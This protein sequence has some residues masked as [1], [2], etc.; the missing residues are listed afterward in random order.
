MATVPSATDL[1][2]TI[3]E[4]SRLRILNALVAA[5]LFVSDLQA[6]LGLPQPTVSRHLRV[7]RDAGVVRDTPIGPYV[8][9]RLHGPS[10]PRGRLVRQ[11]IEAVAGDEGMRGDRHHAQ[12]RSRDHFRERTGTMV[13][14]LT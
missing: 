11:V 9:Y 2:L 8:L 14:A 10:S 7:L 13:E 3:A 12:Q 1:L 6:I 5:P 4:A